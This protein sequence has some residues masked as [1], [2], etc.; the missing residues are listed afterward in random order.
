MRYQESRSAIVERVEK[1]ELSKQLRDDHWA[2]KLGKLV[3]RLRRARKMSQAALSVAAG[4][5]TQTISNFE[6]GRVVPAVETLCRIAA[7]LN[8]DPATL[9]RVCSG[10]KSENGRVDYAEVI[11]LMRGLDSDETR[12]VMDH[13]R[14]VRSWALERQRASERK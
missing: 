7:G 4:V 11:E 12:L 1:P 14:L 13:I 9:L 3:Q 6:T 10:D 8:A 2:Q 5:S